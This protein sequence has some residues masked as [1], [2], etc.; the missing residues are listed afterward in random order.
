MSRQCA[1]LTKH[2]VKGA[3][4]AAWT[5][6]ED[7]VQPVTPGHPPCRLAEQAFRAVTR[8]GGTHFPRCHH[9]DTRR[10]GTAGIPDMDTQQVT[11]TAPWTAQDGDDLATVT[12]PR[13]VCHRHH[14]TPPA[15]RAHDGGDCSRYGDR[16]GSACGP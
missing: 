16:H 12:Q 2:L 1:Q 14:F 4:R 7:D 8:D 15:N 10:A 9:G 11:G 5:R 13:V 3:L 6:H